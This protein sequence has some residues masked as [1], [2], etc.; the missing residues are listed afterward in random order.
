MEE[1]AMKNDKRIRK[2]NVIAFDIGTT[3][4]KIA[5]GK[6]NN[7]KLIVKRV[8]SFDTPASSISN[9]RIS[10]INALV[11]FLKGVL[12]DEK[13]KE[14]YAIV[15]IKSSSIINREL[16]VPYNEN[17][18]ELNKMIQYELSQFS[19]IS[20][21]NYIPQ[22]QILDEFF[23]EKVKMVRV[24]VSSLERNIVE[25]Y[26][27]LIRQVGLKPYVFDVHFNAISKFFDVYNSEADRE[28]TVAV[29][30]IGFDGTD[31]AI[32]QD[33][34]YRMSKTMDYGSNTLERVFKDDLKLDYNARNIEYLFT[35]GGETQ[36]KLVEDTLGYMITE[37]QEILRYHISR[38]SKNKVDNIFI[39]G[40]IG[41]IK[42]LVDYIADQ[43]GFELYEF[44]VLDRVLIGY[45]GGYDIPAYVNVL[46]SLVRR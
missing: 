39:T 45:N 28:M 25:D 35:K 32:I 22:Y 19:T 17:K 24:L 10:D 20:M 46:G 9:G 41:S 16:I 8:L 43:V 13:I 27:S 33:G 36:R 5:I 30:D 3:V 44:K 18:E 31:V 1:Y 37:I 11:K 42:P 15:N 4:T 21:E 14:K 38:D 7:K 26:L 29:I 12:L 6:H 34:K 2:K 23:D 40:G